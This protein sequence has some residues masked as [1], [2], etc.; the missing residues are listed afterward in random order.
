MIFPGMNMMNGNLAES[1]RTSSEQS[2]AAFRI[3]TFIA[4]K[5]ANWDSPAT[6]IS[7]HIV[8]RASS[9]GK[10]CGRRNS[11]FGTNSNRQRTHT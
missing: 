5:P 11:R 8:G 10:T 9:L 2:R 3:E 6:N 1:V 7:P 4:A